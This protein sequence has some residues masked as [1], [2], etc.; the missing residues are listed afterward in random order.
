MFASGCLFYSA[1]VADSGWQSLLLCG[2]LFAG[3]GYGLTYVT[4]FVQASENAAKDFRRI[5][6]TIIG[7]TIG[8]SIFFSATFLIYVPVPD[9]DESSENAAVTSEIRSAGVISTTTILFC[10]ISVPINYFY[11]HETVPFLLYHNYR[12]EDA[13][14]TLATLLSEESNS[15]IVQQEFDEIRETCT[16]DYA[17]FAEGKI[18]QSAHRSLLSIALSARI[19]SAQSF[20]VPVIVLFAKIIQ[21]YYLGLI[22]KD[23]S[24]M[25]DTADKSSPNNTDI[26]IMDLSQELIDIREAIH[27]YNSA[28]KSFMF[29]WFVF[30]LVFTLLSN[31]FNWK[32][33]LHLT[34][35][36]AGASIL[37]CV[38]VVFVGIFKNFVGTLTFLVL[39]I[40]F[41]F[42]SLPV[43]VLGFTYLAECFPLSTKSKS[44]GFVT[45]C[46]CIFNIILITTNLRYYTLEPEFIPMGIILC[47]L[48]YKLYNTVPN[49]NGFSLA[50]AKQAYLHSTAGKLWW[51]F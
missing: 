4:I 21:A 43:D 36:I 39:I 34:T 29:S 7:G 49:T 42:L 20:N 15:L 38:I 6:I 31:Y 41:Q 28:V 45:I 22:R 11:S 47:L 5:L 10:F 3:I 18:F 33:G 26:T 1:D 25:E 14:F 30:G 40:Y 51:Q 32:R 23:L 8:F 2:R 24:K 9:L 46:E 27:I 44:I 48:G 19:A 35:F 13:E 17:E 50:A 16:N 37:S 12:K